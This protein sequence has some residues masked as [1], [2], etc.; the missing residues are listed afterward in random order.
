[1]VFQCAHDPGMC[2]TWESNSGANACFVCEPED[3]TGGLTP[4]PSVANPEDPEGRVIGWQTGRDPRSSDPMSAFLDER[5][6]FELPD[7]IRES[8][9]FCTRI[10]GVPCWIQSPADAPDRSAGWRFAVQL[11]S[12]Y[13]FLRAPKVEVEWISPDDENY[14]GRTHVAAGPNF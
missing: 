11:D 1:F 4:A 5:R 6:R 3:L 10:G 12:T 8:V 14:E 2:A 9:T 7:A 13:S